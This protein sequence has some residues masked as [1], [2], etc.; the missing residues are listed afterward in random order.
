[1]PGAITDVLQNMERP[2][3][4]AH[5]DGQSEF[6]GVPLTHEQSLQLTLVDACPSQSQ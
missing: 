5:P 3:D 6:L 4:E 1:M 2:R